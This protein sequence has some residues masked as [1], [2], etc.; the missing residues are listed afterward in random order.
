VRF[1]RGSSVVRRRRDGQFDLVLAEPG[2]DAIRHLL[3]QLDVALESSPDDPGLRRLQPPA[4]LDDPDKEAAYRLLAG[5]ELRTKRREAIDAVIATLERDEL[6]ED[7]VW[8][9]LRSINAIRLV[10]G[11]RLDVS[12]DEDSLVEPDEDDPDASLW[13]AYQLTSIILQELVLALES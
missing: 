5:D 13:H 4:Y 12:E 8:L 3:G 10:V 2:R 9:W 7:E 1:F 6:T 11:T